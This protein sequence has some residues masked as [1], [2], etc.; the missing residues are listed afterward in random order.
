[1]S[2][3]KS[4]CNIPP[5]IKIYLTEIAERLQE[6]HASLMVGAGFSKNAEGNDN[7]RKI[8]S[9]NELAEKFFDKLNE[10]NTNK[11]EFLNPLKLASEVEATFGRPTLNKIIKSNMPDDKFQP[12]ELH[13]KLLSLPWTDVFTTNYDTLLERAARNISQFRYEPV[14]NSEDL[15]LS[16]KP[17]II[18]LHGSFPSQ[19]PFI[20]TEEDF[21][22]YPKDNAP[23]VNTVQQSLLENTLCL[24]GFSGDDPNFLNWIGWIR[25]NLGK[26]NSLKMYLIG[27]LSLSTGQRKLL[28]DRNIIPIDISF[29]STDHYEAL[30]LF[31]DFLLKCLQKRKWPNEESISINSFSNGF[32][33]W[34]T[35]AV[36]IWEKTRKDYPNWLIMPHSH[37]V[38]LQRTFDT[39]FIYHIEKI[40][41]S[42]AIKILYEFNWRL[43]KSLYPLLP[44][45]IQ[46]YQL[47]IDSYNPYPDILQISDSLTPKEQT[48]VDWEE[49]S[50]YWIEL[51]LSLLTHYRQEE[52]EDD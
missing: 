19:R 39:H 6:R 45:W 43:E 17:R 50:I 9:W 23:F 2:N 46:A 30:S 22:T 5:N 41:K 38:S 15:I 26:R 42:L 20:I 16:T 32:E 27:I 7:T 49:I 8:P 51:Q 47:S 18:K 11:K 36:E 33:L 24:I 44:Q 34:A 10:G 31:F 25:D 35:K 1:M 21:R 13:E 29:F 37:R 12:S 40:E 14:V 28:E 48:D 3:N 52:K 4:E